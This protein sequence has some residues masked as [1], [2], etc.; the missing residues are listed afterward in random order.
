MSVSCLGLAGFGV[1][2]LAVQRYQPSP[3]LE[4]VLILALTALP[5]LVMDI[6]F[7]KV[8]RRS[9]TGLN[10][11][12]APDFNLRRSALKVLGLAATLAVLLLCYWVFPEY[13]DR[14]YTVVFDLFR[15]IWP[16]ITAFSVIYIFVVDAYMSDPLDGYWQAGCLVTGR[17]RAVDKEIFGQYCRGWLVKGFF[18]PFMISVFVDN[19]HAIFDSGLLKGDSGFRSI[20][21]FGFALAYG[22]DMAF[23]AL[24]YFLTLRVIDAHIRSTEA[25]VLGW[26]VALAC[27]PPFWP[28]LSNS[29]LPYEAHA[30]YWDRWLES[31]SALYWIWGAMILCCLAIY[32]WSTVLFGCRFSNLTHRGILTN[33]PYRWSKHPAYLSK[34]LSWWL[35]AVPFISNSG[36]AGAAR[37]CLMLGL[38]NCIYFLRARTEER[39][40]S[41]DPTYVAYA[42][43]MNDNGALK[44]L[45]RLAPILRYAPPRTGKS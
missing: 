12:R 27:Y 31:V 32:A 9:T 25:T 7:L 44:W 43:W 15:A 19:M 26:V 37:G 22:V 21:D 45:G 41:R 23:A 3:V 33:G 8:H 16:Y 28:Q 11:D 6:L 4:I 17:L 2:L 39:H 38:L 14:Q 24:G 42:L 36:I 10:W 13:H 40:L 35:I 18:I 29:F 30:V 34:N 20:Y 5:M 1:G